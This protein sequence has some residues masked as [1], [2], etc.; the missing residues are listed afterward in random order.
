VDEESTLAAEALYRSVIPRVVR[1]SR[2]EVA[3]AAKLLEN[4]FRA[5]NIALV[6]EMKMILDRMGID[7]WEVIRAAETK[8]YGF[9]PFYPGPG[10]GGHCIPVDPFY[11]SWVARRHGV[12]ARFIELAGEINVQMP[13]Y[14]VSRLEEVLAKNGRSLRGARVLVL[15]I[16]YKKD[17][18]DPRESPAFEVIR[19]LVERGAR[20]EFHDPHIPVLPAM[21]RWRLPRRRAVPLR[22]ALLRR[23]DAAVIVTDHSRMDYDLVVR[24]VPLVVDTR[25]VIRRNVA[26]VVRA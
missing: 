21:R 16:A 15:G 11:L 1:V 24:H 5:V 4:I 19:L 20:W 9:M 22:A 7:I 2:P 18:D 26:N 6:N 10:W 25:N 13:H 3:E 14:V 8:P 23:F 17:V 12:P